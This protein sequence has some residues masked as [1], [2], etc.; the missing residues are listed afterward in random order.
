MPQNTNSVVFYIVQK[1]FDT[2]SFLLNIWSKI[3]GL[4]KGICWANTD[5]A[6]F[7]TWFWFLSD[8]LSDFYPIFIQF[9]P[10][11]RLSDSTA[12]VWIFSENSSVFGVVILILI[13]F[14]YRHPPLILMTSSTKRKLFLLTWRLLISLSTSSTRAANSAWVSRASFWR[15]WD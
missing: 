6:V 9:F 3:L 12:L 15:P 5:S 10:I 14:W 1:A 13:H 4:S 2:P 8:F 7:I 11:F